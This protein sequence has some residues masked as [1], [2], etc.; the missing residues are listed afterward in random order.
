MCCATYGSPE[1]QK[2]KAN[3]L[4]NLVKNWDTLKKEAGRMSD[5]PVLTKDR[6]IELLQNSPL[7][8]DTAIWIR[9]GSNSTWPAFAVLKEGPWGITGDNPAHLTITDQ[10]EPSYNEPT[11]RSPLSD[12][13]DRS[14]F[15]DL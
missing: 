15:Q 9:S 8:G 13:R 10:K 7:P 1:Q 5:R 14:L 2:A 6:L 4:V 11:T 12:V 3:H